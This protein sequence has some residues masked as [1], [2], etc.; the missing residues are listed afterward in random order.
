MFFGI[1]LVIVSLI[2][3]IFGIKTTNKPIAIVSIILLM[4]TIAV[5]VYFYNNPY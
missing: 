3:L 5:W 1:F 4:I 2:G